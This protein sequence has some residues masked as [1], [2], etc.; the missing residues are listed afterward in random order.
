VLLSDGMANQGVIDHE[1]LERFAEGAQSAHVSTSTIGIG[2]GYDEDLLASIARGGSGNTHF[3]EHGDDAG[4]ALA[5]E[6]DGLLEQSV[7][8]ASLTVRPGDEVSAVRLFNDLPATGIDGGFMVELGD[9][10]AGETRRVL[11]EID[12]PAIAGLGLAKVCDLE[13]RWVEIDSMESKVA[14][15]PVSVNVV[16]GDEAAGRSENTEVTTELAFQRAQRSKREAADALRDGAPE[17]ATVL[18][19]EGSAALQDAIAT[20]PADAAPELA[21]EID[22]LEDMAARAQSESMSVR[23]RA[24]ADYHMKSRKRGR[25]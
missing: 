24:R 7:Q 4:A 11:L 3:A 19:K 5:S 22:V 17:R 14:S 15:I 13:L 18:F 20:V 10:H 1:Q 25:E 23:K 2:H 12:V 6:V 21:R 9:L 16:P 8:A